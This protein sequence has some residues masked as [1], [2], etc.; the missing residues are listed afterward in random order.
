MVG[1]DTIFIWA[2]C[3]SMLIRPRDFVNMSA[4]SSR[5]DTWCK[6][7][8]PFH[9]INNMMMSNV[10]KFPSFCRSLTGGDLNIGG[11]VELR[12]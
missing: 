11:V 3:L 5:V 10:Y 8:L 7:T 12:L 9:I 1:V 4:M 2:L 6:T